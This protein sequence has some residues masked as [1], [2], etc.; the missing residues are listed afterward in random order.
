MSPCELA[1]GVGLRP[2]TAADLIVA[3]VREAL[4]DRLIRRL[5]TIDRRVGEPGFVEAAARL[6]AEAVG[7]SAVELGAVSVPNPSGRVSEAL[8]VGSVAEAA[9]VL[10]S[11]GGDLAFE[12]KVVF[13]I[14]IAAAELDF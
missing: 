13:G 8:G 3:A 5:A 2:G 14:V 9:A 4:G 6:G 12:K 7:F 1:V 10:A 11:G